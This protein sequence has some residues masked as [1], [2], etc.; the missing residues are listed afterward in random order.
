MSKI[1]ST[2]SVEINVILKLTE[3]E[4]RALYN[5]TGYGPKHFLDWFYKH[6]GKHYLKPH[7]RGLISLFKTIQAELPQHLK[8]ADEARKVFNK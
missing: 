3:E 4:A 2:S 5:I 8:R 6:L 7:E 1:L